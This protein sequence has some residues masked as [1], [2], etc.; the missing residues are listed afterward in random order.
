MRDKL[1][2]CWQELNYERMEAAPESM[3]PIIM[4]M[5]RI[6]TV[7]WDRYHFIVNY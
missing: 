2:F 7:L 4:K 6:K 3:Y 5:A 1:I